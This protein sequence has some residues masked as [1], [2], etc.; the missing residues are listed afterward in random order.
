MDKEILYWCL[1]VRKGHRWIAVFIAPLNEL[2]QYSESLKTTAAKR[3]LNM[4]GMPKKKQ[5]VLFMDAV[6]N[7]GVLRST[8]N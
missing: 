5:R 8:L 3:F 1:Q 4:H 6:K 7:S 2:E